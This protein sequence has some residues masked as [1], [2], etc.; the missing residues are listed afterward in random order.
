MARKADYSEIYPY[1]G[2]GQ[3]VFPLKGIG[4]SRF[5]TIFDSVPFKGTYQ[6]F[7]SSIICTTVSQASSKFTSAAYSKFR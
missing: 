5:L 7:V 1:I 3:S 2:I 6:K 4:Q